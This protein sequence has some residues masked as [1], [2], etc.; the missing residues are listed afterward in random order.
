MASNSSIAAV[1]GAAYLLLEDD[2]KEEKRP[3]PRSVWVHDWIKK[4]DTEGFYVKLL[5]ELRSNQP[6]HYRN[7]VRMSGDDFDFL[8]NLVTPLIQKQE[9]PMRK[10]ISAGERLALTLRFLAT[11]ENFKSLQYLF[12]IPQTTISRIVPETC[13]AIYKV[14][15]D[16]YMKVS[17][18]CR[19]ILI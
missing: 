15:K 2:E 4:R 3:R 6:Q 17:L 1:L 12:L 8:L 19:F 10:P 9:T 13:D 7:F 5:R 16:K 14:L 18:F 11:G